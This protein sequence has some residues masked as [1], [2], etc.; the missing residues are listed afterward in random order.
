[1][2]PADGDRLDAVLERARAAGFL[3]PGPVDRQRAHAEGFAGVVERALGRAPAAVADLGTGGG[4]PGLV[5][6]ARWRE[7][8]V[9]LIEAMARRSEFL[10]RATEELHWQNR[11]RVLRVR[12]EDA[13]RDPELR[14]G[15]DVVTARGFDRPAVTAEIAAGLVRPGGLVVVSEP[16]GGDPARWPDAPLSELGLGSPR[17]DSARIDTSRM[18]DEQDASFAILAKVGPCPADRPRPTKALVKRPA[19]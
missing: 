10:E 17:I 15:F 9:V 3:G 11:V 1:V 16:P 18:G 14:E 2:I 6:A 8:S 4:V 5:L 13:A 19:W 12:A 7:A